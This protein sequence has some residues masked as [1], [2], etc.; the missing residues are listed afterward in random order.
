MLAGSSMP[1][2][3]NLI[4]ARQVLA[5]LEQRMKD[6]GL[7]PHPGRTGSSTSGTPTAA[8]PWDGP[9]SLDFLGDAFRPRDSMGKDGRAVKRTSEPVT[10]WQFH[11]LTAPNLGATRELDRP[12]HPWVHSPRPVPPFGTAPSDCRN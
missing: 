3:V 9:V 8:V 10:G 4:R 7:E 2:L 12:G 11:R 6:V 1:P 5:V